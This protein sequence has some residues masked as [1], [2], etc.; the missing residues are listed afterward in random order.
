MISTRG[1]YA[2]RVMLD[3]AEHQDG[4]FTPMKEVAARQEISLKY[5]EQIMPL[6]T[7]EHMVEGHH[8]KGGGYRLCHEPGSICIGDIL[9][10]T[11]ESLTPVSCLGCDAKPCE[12]EGICKTLPMWKKFEKITNDFFDS[13]SLADLLGSETAGDY[14]I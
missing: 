10:A 2:I 11:H 3:L 14:V 5:V 4:G 12:K 6:L 1:R 9:R 13:I 7:K 8:G